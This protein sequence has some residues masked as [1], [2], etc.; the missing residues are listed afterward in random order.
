[1]EDSL[2]T[3]FLEA[4]FR[5]LGINAD[6]DHVIEF[7]NHPQWMTFFY[8]RLYELI[9][10]TGY[11]G[12]KENI[13]E[14]VNFL[15]KKYQEIPEI[16][17]TKTT[18]S[19]WFSTKSRPS[20]ESRSRSKMYD[21][22]FV[23]HFNYEEVRH[24]FDYIY[25]DRCFN[26]RSIEEAVY[27]YCFSN[28]LDYVHARKLLTEAERILAE[29]PSEEAQPLLYTHIMEKD[30]HSLKSDS[31]FLAYIKANQPSFSNFNQSA[32]NQLQKLIGKIKGTEED[33]KQFNLFRKDPKS[34]LSFQSENIDKTF[35][36]YV[37]REFIHENLGS[38]Y[39][40]LL[41]NIKGMNL[42][43]TDF[44]LFQILG[45]NLA[46][47]RCETPSGS[48]AKHARLTELARKNLPSDQNLSNILRSK[49]NVSFDV[50]HKMILLLHFYSFCMENNHSGDCQEFHENYMDDANDLLNTC[51]YGPLYHD[52]PYDWIFWFV[53][54]TERPLDTFR[55][56]IAEAV[57]D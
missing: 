8:E 3:K 27:C 35:G 2:Y 36:G 57:N 39:A 41:E 11:K 44:M 5:G 56:I 40:K 48:F 43:S 23:L 37:V 15:Y 29:K 51:G 34:F 6:I 16:S 46:H 33:Q 12:A 54:K 25:L 55:D 20:F 50:I 52:N 53:T 24:F 18:L 13:S 49:Q 21:L 32:R 19:S 45:I 42:A 4:Y 30:I 26:C 10:Q 38:D 47:Y 28:A 14:Q 1:M 31:D 9:Q 22:C 17:I 7:L